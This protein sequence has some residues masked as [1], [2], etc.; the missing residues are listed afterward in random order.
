MALRARCSG[1]IFGLQ[2]SSVI[3]S[4]SFRLKDHHQNAG[5]EIDQ[6]VRVTALIG[7][8]TSSFTIARSRS[9]S[10]RTLTSL[11]CVNNRWQKVSVNAVL[12]LPWRR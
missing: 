4:S 2:R 1:L 8:A 10:C 12:N 5:H 11:A 3:D 9:C 7:T 6:F